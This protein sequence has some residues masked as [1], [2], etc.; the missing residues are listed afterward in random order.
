MGCGSSSAVNVGPMPEAQCTRMITIDQIKQKLIGSQD[1]VEKG[2]YGSFFKF[3][4]IKNFISDPVTINAI[5]QNFD[6]AIQCPIRVKQ[7]SRAKIG[8]KY[9]HKVIKLIDKQACINFFNNLAIQSELGGCKVMFPNTDNTFFQEILRYREILNDYKKDVIDI[10]AVQQI[11][12]DIISWKLEE[13]RKSMIQ[14]LKQETEI[15]KQNQKDL[16]YLLTHQQS[17]TIEDLQSVVDK[18]SEELDISKLDRPKLLKIL[19]EIL[20]NIPLK[21]SKIPDSITELNSINFKKQTIISFSLI[22]KITK[23]EIDFIF[24]ENCIDTIDNL[25]LIN[26]KDFMIKI[27]NDIYTLHSHN[28]YHLDIKEKNIMSCQNKIKLIDFG[29]SINI[30]PNVINTEL[31]DY[32]DN[33]NIGGSPFYQNP[34]IYALIQQ[35][36]NINDI[37]KR[38]TEAYSG[39]CTYADDSDKSE[40]E[41]Y[42]KFPR[43]FA[44]FYNLTTTNKLEK[45]LTKTVPNANNT[46]KI[47]F[48]KHLFIRQDWYSLAV[49]L[50]VLYDKFENSSLPSHQIFEEGILQLAQ[51]ESKYFK[52]GTVVNTILNAFGITAQKGGV[53]SVT[54]QKI[55]LPNQKRLRKV[56]KYMNKYFI[57]SKEQWIEIKI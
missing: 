10:L 7:G 25:S 42:K 20:K 13:S 33:Y 51:L 4:T 5:I 21:I 46:D 47:S 31:S 54:K 22:D 49:I 9:K 56:Y 39:F 38:M 34:V 11:P 43:V 32:L 3:D 14:K 36:Y 12:M 48:Y 1:K 19:R 37:L 6:V 41:I 27:V 18:F 53:Y 16:I 28:I 35:N 44:E 8:K 45:L 50:L 30:P 2:S 55:S 23:E 40:I 57:K 15:L 17:Y 29:L 52:D 26:F 24:L